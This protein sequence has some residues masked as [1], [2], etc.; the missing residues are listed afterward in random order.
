MTE[1]DFIKTYDEWADAIF[2][3]CSFRLSDREAAKDL[4]Q[5]I[6]IRV[7]EYV[8]RGEK[9][10]NMKAFLYRVAHNRIVDEFR[11]RGRI[12]SLETLEDE[13]GFDVPEEES[14]ADLFDTFDA[15]HALEAIPR[16]TPR[17]R[18]VLIMRFVDGLPPKEIAGILKEPEN[19]I[20]VRIHR[21]TRKLAALLHYDHA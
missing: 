12:D 5:D 17:Y 13:F 11:K 18:E 4:T 9:V 3:H 19:N 10:E 7:W 14:V 6:F 8:S 15:R 1:H 16:L 20:S 21:A 2:R